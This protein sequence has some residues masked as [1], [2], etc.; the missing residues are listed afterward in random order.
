MMNKPI[1][2]FDSGVGGLSCVPAIKNLLPKEQI[3]FYGDTARAPYGSRSA[4][5]IISFSLESAK[6]LTGMGCKLL[7]VA[8]NTISCVALDAIKEAF[9]DIPVV[10]I[11][12]PAA[13]E[14]TRLYDGKRVG[15]IGTEAS[16][17]SGAHEKAV[18]ACGFKGVYFAKACPGFVP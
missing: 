7:S 4:E 14:I 10:G 12:N 11:I 5:E 17:K 3:I 16:V 18:L 1:G 6:L 13:K 8:C 2:L 9:P 15:L